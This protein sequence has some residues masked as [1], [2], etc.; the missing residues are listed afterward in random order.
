MIKL[1]YVYECSDGF[2][3]EDGEEAEKHE[4]QL[5]MNRFHEDM[6]KAIHEEVSKAFE[7]IAIKWDD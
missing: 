4:H 3:T 7:R 6:R 5:W 1:H 2:R